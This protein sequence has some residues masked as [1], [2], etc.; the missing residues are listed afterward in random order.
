MNYI[1]GK[2]TEHHTRKPM[3]KSSIIEK[4]AIN[5]YTYIHTHELTGSCNSASSQAPQPPSSQLV[6]LPALSKKRLVTGIQHRQQND[7]FPSPL[8]HYNF[9]MTDT[10][11]V[12]LK[13]P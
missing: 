5:T 13:E 10:K 1:G 12:L 9:F 6:D 2:K 7:H 11:G 8:M 4:L 3:E